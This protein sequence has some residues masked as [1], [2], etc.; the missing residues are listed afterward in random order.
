MRGPEYYAMDTWVCPDCKREASGKI[1]KCRKCGRAKPTY[2]PKETKAERPKQDG[3]EVF[4]KSTCV[5][6]D[7]SRGPQK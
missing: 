6:K 2:A 3:E 7:G 5:M 4:F 1:K